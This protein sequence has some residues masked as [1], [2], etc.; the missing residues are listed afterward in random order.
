MIY[1]VRNV[2]VSLLL[3]PFFAGCSTTP[4]APISDLITTGSHQYPP[5]SVF[6][7]VPSQAFDREC[8]EFDEGSVLDRCTTS[9]INNLAF[10]SNLSESAYFHQVYNQNGEIDYKIWFATASFTHDGIVHYSNAVISGLSVMLIPVV[11]TAQVKAELTV[12]WRGNLLKTYRY[13]LSMEELLAIWKRPGSGEKIFSTRLAAEFLK[14]AKC[15][16]HL[17]AGVYL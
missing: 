15:G 14:D 3:A 16:T 2:W 12:I 17:H 11:L 9:M 1:R 10:R 8:E 7:K 6:Y 4:I 5:V 13:E